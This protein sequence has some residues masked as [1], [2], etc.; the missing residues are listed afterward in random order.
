MTWSWRVFR[1]RDPDFP[2][3]LGCGSNLSPGA[4]RQVAAGVQKRYAQQLLPPKRRNLWFLPPRLRHTVLE[5]TVRYPVGLRSRH[6]KAAVTKALRRS[7]EA[8]LLHTRLM[9][10]GYDRRVT[11]HQ[12][13]RDL[14]RRVDGCAGTRHRSQ[15]AGSAVACSALPLYARSAAD[16][17]GLPWSDDHST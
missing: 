3:V 8:G 7:A 11:Y 6:R 15:V 14:Q 9:G 10:L 16:L 1:F 17:S 5:A 4:A 12:E 2:H 13:W